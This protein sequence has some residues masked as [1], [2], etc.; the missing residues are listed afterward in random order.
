MIMQKLYAAMKNEESR[1]YVA[2]MS[3]MGFQHISAISDSVT[4]FEYLVLS[5]QIIQVSTKTDGGILQTLLMR[6]LS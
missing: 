4:D 3:A 2:F 1:M 5:P 6:P